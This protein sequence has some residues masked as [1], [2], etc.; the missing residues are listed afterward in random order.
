MDRRE[1]LKKSALG[2]GI[3]LTLP[4]ITTIL[5]SCTP[6][7]API[8]WDPRSLSEDQI[9]TVGGIAD[10]ILPKTNTPG[11]MD[12]MLDRFVDIM[13]DVSYEEKEKREF[14]DQLESFM[15]DCRSKYGEDF[16]NCSDS[17]K[18]EIITSLESS[19]TKTTSQVW[20][21]DIQ[22]PMSVTFYRKLKGLILTGYYTSEDVG[23]NILSYDPIPGKQIGCIPLSEVGNSWTEG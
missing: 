22:T 11:A 5:N 14:T 6:S 13:I 19:S 8:S 17:Q 20:G 10:T 2:I 18:N 4:A 7:E 9:R 16:Q 15:A 21:K 12:L 23:K 1:L 3:T